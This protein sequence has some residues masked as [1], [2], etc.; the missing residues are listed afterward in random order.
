[1]I[2]IVSLY[3]PNMPMQYTATFHGCKNDNFQ[4]KIVIFFH[5]TKAVLTSTHNL[6]FRAKIRTKAYPC[7]RQF[8]NKKW[9]VRGSTLSKNL[10]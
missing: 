10:T 8:Y 6:C 3:Y 1:M 2:L 5:I 7:K 9:G 4:T